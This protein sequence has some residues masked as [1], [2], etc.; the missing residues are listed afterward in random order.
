MVKS[1][2]LSDRVKSK[3]LLYRV[4]IKVTLILHSGE[5]T[6]VLQSK[7]LTAVLQKVN[8]FPTEEGRTGPRQ[9]TDIMTRPSKSISI[10]FCLSEVVNI[11]EGFFFYQIRITSTSCTQELW[12][13]WIHVVV[14]TNVPYSIWGCPFT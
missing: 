2:L 1:K 5:Q 11:L 10:I 7:E 9:N 4:K 13:L 6:A 3:R 14:D 12:N 8:W